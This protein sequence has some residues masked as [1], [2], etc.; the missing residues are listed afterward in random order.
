MGYE[1]RP[2]DSLEG[3]RESGIALAVH[4]RLCAQGPKEGR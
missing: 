3:N 1:Y 2:M 4:Y